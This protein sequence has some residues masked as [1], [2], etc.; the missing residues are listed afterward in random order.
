MLSCIIFFPEY[1]NILSKILKIDTFD[2]ETD[3]NKI[4]KFSDYPTCVKLVDLDPDR[5]KNG[6]SEPNQHQNDADTQHGS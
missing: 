5:H 1:I 3:V 4:E 6:K 2:A